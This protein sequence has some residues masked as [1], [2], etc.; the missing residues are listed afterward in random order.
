MV[1]TNRFRAMV[2]TGLAVTAAVFVAA[3]SSGASLGIVGD[4]ISDEYHAPLAGP[5]LGYEGLN[6]VEQLSRA[7]RLDFGSFDST[8]GAL[9]LSGGFANNFALKGAKVT[10]GNILDSPTNPFGVF[11]PGL[12]AIGQNFDQQ[13]VS[14]AAAFAAGRIDAGLIQGGANDVFER[15]FNGESFD[16]SDAG[17]QAFKNE[18]V[19]AFDSLLQTP[20][21]GGGILADETIALALVP[22]NANF[23]TAAGIRAINEDLI[24]LA[25]TYSVPTVDLQAATFSRVDFTDPAFPVAIGEFE[26]PLFS[27]ASNDDLVSALDPASV[28]EEQCGFSNGTPPFGN[29]TGINPFGASG[30][31]TEAYQLTGTQDDFIHPTTLFQGLIANDVIGVFNEHFGFDIALLS[32]REITDVALGIPEPTGAVL[33]GMAIATVAIGLRGRRPRP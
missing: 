3:G 19:T 18:L 14:L 23:S 15:F 30:C 17:F 1:W 22:L 29:G 10:G 24:A 33:F 31:P 12:S 28:G 16:P 7:G 9:G 2:L 6:W 32:D 4:S 20:V 5:F 21:P 25:A 8:P 27:I 26:I 11:V 13:A